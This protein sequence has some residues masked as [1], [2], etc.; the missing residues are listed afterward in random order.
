MSCIIASAPC[1][2]ERHD[3]TPNYKSEPTESNEGNYS[4]FGKNRLLMPYFLSLSDYLRELFFF[5]L[6]IDQL[7]NVC[8][9]LRTNR[10]YMKKR[11]SLENTFINR[12]A[13]DILRFFIPPLLRIEY[14]IIPNAFNHENIAW[15]SCLC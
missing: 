11:V 6:N 15:F 9:I 7:P 10:Y 14:N 1:C 13:A 2:W 12:A 4:E 8:F 3:R 5:S